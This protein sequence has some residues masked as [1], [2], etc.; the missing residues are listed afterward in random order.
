MVLKPLANGMGWNL[1]AFLQSSDRR[2]SSFMKWRQRV[3]QGSR[4]FDPKPQIFNNINVWWVWQ[5]HNSWNIIFKS[6][7]PGL[8]VMLKP[9]SFVAKMLS[10]NRPQIGFQDWNI[11]LCI[12]ITIDKATCYNFVICN[13][14]PHHTR[15]P[16]LTRGHMHWE[17][18]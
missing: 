13:A 17:S 4:W 6:V 11:F 3:L 14:T 1:T 5:P 16:S 2:K 10:I 8:Y 9:V 7:V 12:Y 15:Y 18:L